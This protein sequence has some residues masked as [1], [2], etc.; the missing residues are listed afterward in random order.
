MHYAA[1]V[2]PVTEKEAKGDSVQYAAVVGPMTS[3]AATGDSVHYAQS[4]SRK[5]SDRIFRE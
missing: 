3:E 1:V 4:L 2:D 5:L